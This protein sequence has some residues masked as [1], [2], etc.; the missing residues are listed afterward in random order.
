MTQLG[1]LS[2]ALALAAAPGLAQGPVVIE[3]SQIIIHPTILWP[4]P[5]PLP[6]E[7]RVRVEFDAQGTDWGAVYLDGRLIY[8]P[9][10]F[11]R[12]K[13]LYLPPG[14]YRL[15]ITGVVRSDLWAS[16]YLD[17]GRDHSQIVVVRFSK[18][19]GVTVSGGPYVWIPD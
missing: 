18:A 16:G 1:G 19:G 4:Y 14:G 12:Q 9:H 8:R 15:E 13:T 7:H 2:L 10:N 11:D 5:R 3:S 6:R 17:L